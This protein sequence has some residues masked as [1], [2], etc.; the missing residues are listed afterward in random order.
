VQDALKYI[1]G[2]SEEE[3]KNQLQ[4]LKKRIEEVEKKL[5]EVKGQVE[6]LLVG[7]K[8]FFINEVENGLLYS[9]FVVEDGVAKIKTR[10]GAARE[11]LVTDLVDT[12]KFH[13]VVK[14]VFRKLTEKGRVL[15]VG[16]RGIGKS[17][18]AAY[19]IWNSLI[20]GLGDITLDEPRDAVI[21]I[22]SLSSAGATKINDLVKATSRRIVIIYDPSPIEAYIEPE[23]MKE[24]RYDLENMKDTL[25]NLEQVRDAWVIIVLPQEFYD[26]ISKDKKL[27]SVLESVES[28]KVDVNLRDEDF[29]RGIIKSYSGCQVVPEELVKIIKQKYRGGHTL[30]AKYAG[31]WLRNKKCKVKDVVEVLNVSEPKLFFAHYIWHVV[32]GGS[33]DL[34]MKV[35]VP[36]MLHAAFGAISE[37]ITYITKAVNV[38]GV[39]RLVDKDSLKNIQLTDLREEKLEPIAKWLSIKHEDLVKEVLEELAGLH[40]ENKKKK[41]IE[42]GLES[43]VNSLEWGY[44]KVLKEL[45]DIKVLERERVR[46]NL[47]SFIGKRLKLI[48]K[49]FSNNYWKRAALIIGHSLTGH[50]LLPRAGDLPEDVV[51]ILND[52]LKPYG[53]DDYLL[54]DN[55]ISYLV[56]DLFVYDLNMPLYIS[57]SSSFTRIFTNKY[58]G[59]IEEAKKLLES[60][61]KREDKIY[62]FEGCYALGLASIVAYAARLGKDISTDDA[63]ATLHI[64]RLAIQSTTSTFHI[65]LT[66][67]ALKPLLDMAPHRYLGL[68]SLA[69][70]VEFLDRYTV[71]LVFDELNYILNKHYDEVKKHAWSLVHAVRACSELFKKHLIYLDYKVVE[72]MVGRVVELLRE[73]DD[74]VLGTIAWAFA[75]SPALIREHIRMLM[76]REL[77]IDVIKKVD[78][79]LNK[80]NKLRE[81]VEELQ[82][83]KEFVSYVKSI[84]IE[85]DENTVKEIIMGPLLYLEDTL[86]YYK[87][88]KDELNEAARL[89]EKVANG[90][91][92]IG[93]FENYLISRMWVLRVKA[94][95]SSLASNDLVKEYDQLFNEALNNRKPTATY[96]DITS[97]IL[98]NYLVSLALTNN[99]NK[100][101]KKYSVMTRLILNTLLGP[102]NGLD[103]R[104]KDMLMVGPEKL[105]MVFKEEM[106]NE[107]LP[108]LKVAYGLVKPEDGIK[109]C[110]ELVEDQ[111]EI[112]KDAV[113]AGG[114]RGDV[115]ERVKRLLI[116]DFRESILEKEKRDLLKELGVDDNE[117]LSMFNKFMELVYGLDGR[118]LVQL[119]APKNSR[120]HLAL[121]LYAL[122]NGNHEL[123]KAYALYG[124]T[125]SYPNK[126]LTRLFLEVYKACCDLSGEN[127]RKALA[128]LFFY[129][130]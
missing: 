102:K 67:H 79:V 120:V 23:A 114:G 105:I 101:N 1:I 123:V 61:R 109:E 5:S 29:L 57:G 66:L 117:L 31:I 128:R 50:F 6:G 26:E 104:L 55:E 28:S 106:H 17:T 42:N 49:P 11:E 73:L 36:L 34:A 113:L 9:N 87:L 103:D 27:K 97:A 19:V 81:N 63:D 130:V 115:I 111:A 116:S 54:V 99:T 100:V 16:P 59:A 13:D 90:R 125:K 45:E 89:F 68:I 48:L 112:C 62:G 40:G 56:H 41:Y 38:G 74:T 95:E 71:R 91:K 35:S 15:L 88:D 10:I 77:H 43:L 82:R 52:A 18:L 80:L 44:D 124:T 122:I 86:A 21:R 64:A 70:S 126:L 78:Y 92:E 65:G 20:G 33:M 98:G 96:L 24:A 37:E 118:S 51:E 4:E 3:F 119:I 94:I 93:D 83:D 85:A 12:G 108:A 121:M 110:E 39:W 76:E 46:E 107:L 22:D 69:S 7:S 58:E 8:V 32:L 129:Y 60:W 47:A 127:F 2:L 75:L 30:I 72:E 25:K 53:I 14:E 84:F